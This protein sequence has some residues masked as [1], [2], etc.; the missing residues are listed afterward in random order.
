MK[1]L[2]APVEVEGLSVCA[3]FYDVFHKEPAPSRR[4]EY[5]NVTNAPL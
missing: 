5:Q 3:I 1:T 4:S 2:P